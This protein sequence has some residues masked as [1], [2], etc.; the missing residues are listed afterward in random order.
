MTLEKIRMAFLEKMTFR[1]GTEEC[2]LCFEQVEKGA[3]TILGEKNKIS[4]LQNGLVEER[5]WNRCQHLTLQSTKR[6]CQPTKE[7]IIHMYRDE[8]TKVRTKI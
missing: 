8:I 1:L 3:N 2:Q 4:S 7:L 6:P 5:G